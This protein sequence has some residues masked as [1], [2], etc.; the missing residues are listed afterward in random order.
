MCGQ[1]IKAGSRIAKQ[2]V[3]GEVLWMHENCWVPG[4]PSRY[5]QSLDREFKRLIG[6]GGGMST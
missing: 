6:G 1:L 3:D 2:M 5:T 4:G